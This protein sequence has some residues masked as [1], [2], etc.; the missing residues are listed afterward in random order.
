M[1]DAT[2]HKVRDL[3]LKMLHVEKELQATQ[4][5][6]GLG[7]WLGG[8][9]AGQMARANE[10][11]RKRLEDKLEDLK[12]KLSEL[13]GGEETMTPE[14]ADVAAEPAAPAKPAKKAAATKATA[15]PKATKKS[16]KKPE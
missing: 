16:T 1:D 12:S 2:L 4:H 7:Q 5:N 13:T 14:T 9:H 15:A 6:A 3:K 11:E 8:G 10:R